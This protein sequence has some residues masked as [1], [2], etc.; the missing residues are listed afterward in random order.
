MPSRI[1]RGRRVT[2]AH[3]K[4]LTSRAR[5]G[6]VAR[7]RLHSPLWKKLCMR[8]LTERR[9]GKTQTETFKLWLGE[10]GLGDLK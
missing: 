4:F 2:P 10:R 7:A 9:L 5:L 1:P 6:G 8:F 3:R